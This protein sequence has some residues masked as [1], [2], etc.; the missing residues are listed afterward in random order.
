MPREVKGLAAWQVARELMAWPR[1]MKAAV[2]RV[3]TAEEVWPTVIEE[4]ALT[5]ATLVT[6]GEMVRQAGLL[7]LGLAERQRRERRYQ[8]DDSWIARRLADAHLSDEVA[9]L[10]TEAH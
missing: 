10:E 5:M 2:S 4:A 1:A 7:A 3:V 8:R 6:L 9:W